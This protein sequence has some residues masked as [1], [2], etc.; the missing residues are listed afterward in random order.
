MHHPQA[1]STDSSCLGPGTWGLAPWYWVW[2]E[3]QAPLGALSLPQIGGQG[4]RDRICEALSIGNLPKTHCWHPLLA[5][6]AVL[7]L[8]ATLAH[9]VTFYNRIPQRQFHPPPFPHP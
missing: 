3:R 4:P 7:A 1:I 5:L 8:L 9:L 6:L 2:V